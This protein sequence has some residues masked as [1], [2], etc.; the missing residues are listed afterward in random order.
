MP[1]GPASAAVLERQRPG[2]VPLRLGDLRGGGGL[3]SRRGKPPRPPW[4]SSQCPD[5]G[6]LP[7]PKRPEEA[8]VAQ[9][10]QCL[11][12]AP[13]SAPAPRFGEAGSCFHGEKGGRAPCPCPPRASP[14]TA[15]APSTPP[16]PCARPL[17]LLAL[18]AALR[19]S[20]ARAPDPA[21][22][23]TGHRAP[24]STGPA[25]SGKPPLGRPCALPASA[26]RAHCH[27]LPGALSRASAA[28]P[29][30]TPAPLETSL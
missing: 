20:R 19:P 26:G 28:A 12:A 2:L 3:R 22:R 7:L 18:R 21:P 27:R 30:R 10:Q 1:T 9:G 13:P 29:R 24:R 25:V 11:R 8:P 5:P 6:A 14:G 17:R 4:P 15:G 16:A 23:R